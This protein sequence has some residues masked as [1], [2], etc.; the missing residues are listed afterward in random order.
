MN[1][2]QAFIKGCK[3]QDIVEIYEMRLKDENFVIAKEFSELPN[4]YDVLLK[5]DCKRKVAMFQ[6]SDEWVTVVEAKE[7]NDYDLLMYISK[8]CKAI[9]VCTVCSDV[10]GAC[11]YAILKNGNVETADYSEDI[12]DVDEY[13]SDVLQEEGIEYRTLMFSEIMRDTSIEKTILK[14]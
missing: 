5:E 13:V 2:E 4:S 3:I 11:G 8:K 6:I 7:V 10:I 14:S 9:V 12:D 1:I